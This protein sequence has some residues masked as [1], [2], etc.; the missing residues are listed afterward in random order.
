MYLDNIMNK[1]WQ[2]VFYGSII[3]VAFVLLISGA[4]FW[5]ADEK[6]NDPL[7]TRI[8]T[9]DLSLTEAGALAKIMTITAGITIA[10]IIFVLYSFRSNKLWVKKQSNNFQILGLFLIII[11]VILFA[12]LA[13]K[14]YEIYDFWYKWNKLNQTP[15]KATGVTIIDQINTIKFDIDKYR[16]YGMI[17]GITGSG[18]GIIP[19]GIY[20]R[21]SNSFWR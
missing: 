6:I 9:R 13:W 14:K 7:L 10:T 15:S 20:I 8:D 17:V 1:T 16:H 5:A 19:I 4:L 12:Y 21:R 18:L 11:T 3:L 2:K